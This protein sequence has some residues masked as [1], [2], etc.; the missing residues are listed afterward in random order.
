MPSIHRR[1]G[2]PPRIRD[3]LA[4]QDKIEQDLG[5]LLARMG[6]TG[7]WSVLGFAGLGHYAEQ[8]LGWCR[9]TARERA[10]LAR[11]LR[12]LPLLHLAYRKGRIGFRSALV[13]ARLLRR[14]DVD[15]DG[16]RA[17]IEHAS[18]V[19]TKRLA[20]E[21]RALSRW[22]ATG[23][24]FEPPDPDDSEKGRASG[25]E[26]TPW[27]NSAD[28]E[29][30]R[31]SGAAA[32]GGMAR[33]V[34]PLTDAAWHRSIRRQAGTTCSRLRRLGHQAALSSHPE[35]IFHLSLPEDLAEPFLKTIEAARLACQRSAQA[36]GSGEGHE[37]PPP[38]SAPSLLAARMFSMRARPVPAWVG[39]LAVLEEF[40]RT[41][42][43]PHSG[44]RP[45]REAVYIRDGWR[46]M[47]PGC[48][49]RRNLHDHHLVYR[50]RGGTD[51]LANR[52][53]LCEF[54]H[55]RGEHGG[56]ARCRGEAP[57]GV[58]WSLGREGKGGRYKNERMLRG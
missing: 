21:A 24:S 31:L 55:L 35:K 47:A 11:G 6:E 22:R 18:T 26:D 32:G 48:S 53:C 16:Q 46:C 52:I 7:A 39:L 29:P 30:G 13:L 14:P 56:L 19:T 23:E 33:P 12:R 50:S 25:G 38:D 9:T 51:A 58:I 8:R 40:A 15:A 5:Q 1:T 17:W 2:H 45:S 41:W 37:S 43:T 10:R 4:L 28:R 42:D 54:H 49:S 44:R 36:M 57:L 3:L 20:D 34:W 27:V